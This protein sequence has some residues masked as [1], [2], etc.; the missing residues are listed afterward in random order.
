[1]PAYTAG[2]SI[3]GSDSMPW[4]GA[5]TL[6]FVTSVDAFLPLAATE[7]PEEGICPAACIERAIKGNGNNGNN[8]GDSSDDDSSDDDVGGR[9]ALQS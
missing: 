2:E 9:R 6:S 5:N 7:I 8:G 1:M 4:I 3:V